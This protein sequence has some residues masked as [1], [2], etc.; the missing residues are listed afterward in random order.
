MANAGM[1]FFLSLLSFV[2]GPRK[3][4]KGKRTTDMRPFGWVLVV[5]LIGTASRGATRKLPNCGGSPAVSPAGI[6]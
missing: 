1:S 6:S 4:D 2:I 3:K 5:V